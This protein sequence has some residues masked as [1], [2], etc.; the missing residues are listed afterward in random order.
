MVGLGS[1]NVTRPWP[2]SRCNIQRA[3][4]QTPRGLS[5]VDFIRSFRRSRVHHCY[6]INSGVLAKNSQIASG[7]LLLSFVVIVFHRN[8]VW[9]RSSARRPQTWQ[10]ISRS[11][12]VTTLDFASRVLSNREPWPS[13][14]PPASQPRTAR[15]APTLAASQTVWRRTLHATRTDHPPSPLRQNTFSRGSLTPYYSAA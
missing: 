9:A 10:R 1:R 12:P 15:T 13:S 3:A 6:E 4:R 2:A 8:A 11:S 5:R 14:P 7:F